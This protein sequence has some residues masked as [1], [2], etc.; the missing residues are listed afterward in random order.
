MPPPNAQIEYL[1]SLPD[2]RWY[3]R[4]SRCDDRHT[5][6]DST[7]SSLTASGF[8]LHHATCRIAISPRRAYLHCR[9]LTA[10]S[11]DVAPKAG[12]FGLQIV[13]NGYPTRLAHA[14]ESTRWSLLSDPHL[15]FH[16]PLVEPQYEY[17][18]D[19]TRDWRCAFGMS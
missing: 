10:K 5:P 1:R 19:P 2:Q 8:D 3:V 17:Q 7:A 6:I 18:C 13:F 9:P 12:D 4:V 15:A 16:N 14:C 11:P